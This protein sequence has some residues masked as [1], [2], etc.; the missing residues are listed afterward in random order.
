MLIRGRGGTQKDEVE[1]EA[2]DFEERGYEVAFGVTYVWASL[3]RVLWQWRRLLHRNC[4]VVAPGLAPSVQ[5]ICGK[6]DRDGR[7]NK[8]LALCLTPQA[9]ISSMSRIRQTARAGNERAICLIK[10]KQFS[11]PICLLKDHGHAHFTEERLYSNGIQ[12]F[13]TE[14][15]CV[16]H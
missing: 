3:E 16:V 4:C 9:G 6:G 11:S 14:K 7:G 8:R 1:S 5:L 13:T 10:R 12:L 2:L 15:K